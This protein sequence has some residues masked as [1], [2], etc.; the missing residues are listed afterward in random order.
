MPANEQTSEIRDFFGVKSH[1]LPAV[2]FSDMRHASEDTPAGVQAIFDGSKAIDG[3]SL[4]EFSRAQLAK[5]PPVAS[6]K[7]R[8]TPRKKP[9]STK[10]KK[11]LP[12]SSEF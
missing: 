5:E 11:T 8:P 6:K 4:K 10:K 9:V 1:S 12:K 3:V 7:G 2:V